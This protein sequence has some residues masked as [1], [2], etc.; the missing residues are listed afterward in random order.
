LVE[1]ERRI[2]EE[3]SEKPAHFAPFYSSRGRCVS[4]LEPRKIRKFLILNK[5]KTHWRVIRPDFA[6]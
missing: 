5:L 6:S 1:D 4:R 3:K 2:L